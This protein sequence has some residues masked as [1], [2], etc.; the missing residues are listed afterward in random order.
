MLK[1]KILNANSSHLS[2]FYQTEMLIVF[3]TT[4]YLSSPPWDLAVTIT[5]SEFYGNN[6]MQSLTYIQNRIWFGLVGLWCNN[7]IQVILHQKTHFKVQLPWRKSQR[8]RFLET[9]YLKYLHPLWTFPQICQHADIK[10]INN[11]ATSFQ[12]QILDILYFTR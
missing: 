7:T 10:P 6:C 1:S 2:D 4:S 3:T 5:L 8:K 11:S 12:T 9:K